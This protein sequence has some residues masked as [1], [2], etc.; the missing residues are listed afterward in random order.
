MSGGFFNYEDYKLEEFADKIFEDKEIEEKQLSEI[1]RDLRKV[2]HGYDYW[3]CG[4]C[5]KEYFLKHWNNFLN[6]YKIKF[7][8][9]KESELPVTNCP[10][11]KNKGDK[12]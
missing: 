11:N 6:K 10:L 1:L 7:S 8:K 2:L 3:K 4:D 12:K 9:D 5:S